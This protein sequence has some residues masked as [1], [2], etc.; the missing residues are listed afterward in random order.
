M[1]RANAGYTGSG[2]ADFLSS[3]RDYIEW[4]LDA[5]SAGEYDLT[6]RYANGGTSDRPLDLAVNGQRV[7]RVAFAP[8]GSWTTWRT[9][10]ARVTLAAG[11]NRVRL[12]AIG[13][14]G[15]NIDSMSVAPAA[16]A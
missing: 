7:G 11:Q 6:V 14:S 9:V 15:A 2:Y 13:S 4:T 10:T 16:T 12:T 3:T 1:R 8:T 5:P